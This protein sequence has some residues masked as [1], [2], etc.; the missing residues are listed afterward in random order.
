MPLVVGSSPAGCTSF[1]LTGVEKSS[2]M[3]VHTNK[4]GLDACFGS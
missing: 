2:I 1:Y 4:E 3:G